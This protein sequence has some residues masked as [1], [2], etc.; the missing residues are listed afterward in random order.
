MK[1][2]IIDLLQ[3]MNDE[4]SKNPMMF[5]TDNDDI[6]EMYLA[7]KH[8]QSKVNNGALDDVIV[9][10]GD[11]SLPTTEFKMFDGDDRIA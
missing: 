6:A 11:D 8:H 1:E 5:E 3:W 10:K 4:A 9:I 7:Y 2:I